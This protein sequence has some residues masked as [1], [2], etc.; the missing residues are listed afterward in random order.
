MHRKAFTLFELIIIPFILC[1]IAL[2]VG[3]IANIVQ[4]VHIISDPITALFI[5]KCVGVLFA[6]LGGIL[7]LIGMF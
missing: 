6:P 1:A 3:W 2:L 4:I 7:G 5:F